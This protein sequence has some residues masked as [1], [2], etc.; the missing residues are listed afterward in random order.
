M[1]SFRRYA[2]VLNIFASFVAQYVKMRHFWLHFRHSQNARLDFAKNVQQKQGRNNVKL[3]RGGGEIRIFGQNIYPCTS[4]I[5]LLYDYYLQFAIF[6][7][8]F[9]QNCRQKGCKN[10][11][12]Q[13]IKEIFK[14]S[15]VL[16]G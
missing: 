16:C 6:S 2:P 14:F 10:I 8:L 5:V 7:D 13:T 11:E 1:Q 12:T 9:G 15:V 4:S 3:R